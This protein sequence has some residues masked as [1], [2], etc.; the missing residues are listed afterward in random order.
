MT[1]DIHVDRFA[2]LAVITHST[3]GSR[4]WRNAFWSRQLK[5]AQNWCSA[6][7]VKSGSFGF[8]SSTANGSLLDH[9]VLLMAL[10][11]DHTGKVRY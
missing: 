8:C 4:A 7:T 10:R 11:C 9:K 5:Y 3:N 1:N 2:T 6:E